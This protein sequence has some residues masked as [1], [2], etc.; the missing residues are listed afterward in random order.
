MNQL[1]KQKIYT[2]YMDGVGL[3]CLARVYHQTTKTIYESIKEYQASLNDRTGQR[4]K[5]GAT[6]RG[7]KARVLSSKHE[8]VD[9]N[10]HRKHDKKK[11]KNL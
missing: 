11:N 10:I 5:K 3:R 7:R 9:V 2:R 6:K 1:E 8:A 4:A